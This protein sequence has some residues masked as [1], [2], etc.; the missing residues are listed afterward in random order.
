[1][2]E[3]GAGNKILM[4]FGERVIVASYH[5]QPSFTGQERKPRWKFLKVIH[6]K[7]YN[8]AKITG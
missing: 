3:S 7:V 1:V 8:K 6:A 5:F 2:V 4:V